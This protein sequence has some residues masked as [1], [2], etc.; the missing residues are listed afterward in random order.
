MTATK[1]TLVA[2]PP[3]PEGGGDFPKL[4]DYLGQV[5]VLGP[6]EETTVKTSY[7]EESPATRCIGWAYVNGTLVDL[8]DLLVF[9]QKV[10]SQLRP[11]IESRAY[12]VGRI[13]K[14]GRSFILEE[15]T[16]AKVLAD[17]ESQLSF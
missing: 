7:K 4:A 15:V 8:G 9:W 14:D 11:A 12:V 10:R 13:V 2:P 17:I 16:T 6:T 1:L 5:V 3:A